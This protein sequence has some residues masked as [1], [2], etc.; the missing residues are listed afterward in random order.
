ML[1]INKNVSCAR[2]RDNRNASDFS[3]IMLLGDFDG[4]ELVV[5]EPEGDRVISEKNV[6]HKFCGRDHVH[7][8]L[9]HTGTKFSVVAYSKCRRAQDARQAPSGCNSC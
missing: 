8:N 7:Y 3:W 2:H 1:Q 4:G 6:W 5:E 9:P